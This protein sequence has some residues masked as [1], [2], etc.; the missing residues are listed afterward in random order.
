MTQSG[1]TTTETERVSLST[2]DGDGRTPVFEG[3]PRTVR[4]ALA[5]GESVPP[6]RH[7]GQQILFSVHE[8]EFDLDLGSETLSLSAGEIARFDGAQDIS[9]TAV[10]DA[11][12]L[13]VLADE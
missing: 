2:L 6:H 5:A 10:T 8:G 4:L 7:P 12:A 11:V 9:P 1:D 3:D 13:V